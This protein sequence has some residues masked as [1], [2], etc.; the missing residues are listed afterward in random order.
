MPKIRT[1]SPEKIPNCRE[2]WAKKLGSRERAKKLYKIIGK[3]TMNELTSV[4]GIPHTLEVIRWFNGAKGF[5]E[6]LKKTHKS[7]R[8]AVAIV[9]AAKNLKP[10]PTKR[11]PDHKHLDE[12]HEKVPTIRIK[13]PRHWR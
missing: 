10:E 12:L 4:F 13:H 11:V 1:Q 8:S 3:N 7:G 6:F 5:A 9:Q 2:R